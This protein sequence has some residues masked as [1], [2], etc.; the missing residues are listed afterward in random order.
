M[1]DLR[2]EVRFRD[3]C[4]FGSPFQKRSAPVGGRDPPPRVADRARLGNRRNR[5]LLWREQCETSLDGY[6]PGGCR[7]TLPAMMSLIDAPL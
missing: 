5:R 2:T 7:V 6:R 4:H 3:A 1:G